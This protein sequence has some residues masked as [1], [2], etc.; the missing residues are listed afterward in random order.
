MR[1]FRNFVRAYASLD[2]LVD[3]TL[4]ETQ[5]FIDLF[6]FIGQNFTDGHNP[7]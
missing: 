3:L 7:N 4:E 1:C 6:L 2:I 5:V